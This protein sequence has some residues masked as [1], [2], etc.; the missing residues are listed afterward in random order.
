MSIKKIFVHTHH[1]ASHFTNALW[2]VGVVLLTSFYLTGKASYESASFY[3]FMISLMAVPFVF[4]SGIIDWKQRFKGR[5]TPIF[6]HKRIFGVLFMVVSLL[7]VIW[8]AFDPSV[9]Y[10]ENDMRT[11]YL[12][13]TYLNMGF[14]AYLGHLGGKFI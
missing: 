13:V 14:V 5:S 7:I 10:P 11:I 6:N 3:C 4:F 2:P 1:I 12:L 9:A 8:R